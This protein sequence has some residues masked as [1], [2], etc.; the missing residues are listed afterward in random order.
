MSKE[1]RIFGG[2]VVTD[3]KV[4]VEIIK[5]DLVEQNIIKISSEM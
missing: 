1:N 3:V 4:D 2:K 5:I